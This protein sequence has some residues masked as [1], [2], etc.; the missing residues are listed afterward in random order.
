MV[1]LPQRELL[2]VTDEAIA[3]NCQEPPKHVRVVDISD[4]KAPQ[5][6]W[7]SPV[8][9]GDFCER[10]LRFGPHNLHENRRGAMIDETHIYVTYFNAGLRIFDISA[11]AS[12]REIA[13]FI[14]EIPPG[15]KAIGVNDVLVDQDGL[16]YISDRHR[17]GVY[18]LERTN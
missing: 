16:I 8:P 9:K 15:Q 14:P 7:Q 11:A 2:S 5:V 6:I 12:P 10:G 1:H 17:G 3:H 13:Y 18:I 4:E